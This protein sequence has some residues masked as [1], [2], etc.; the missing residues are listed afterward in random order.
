ME[1]HAEPGRKPRAIDRRLHQALARAFTIGAE[2]LRLAA[3]VEAGEFDG[4]LA[5]AVQPGKPQLAIAD[6]A[7]FGAVTLDQSPKTRT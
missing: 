5:G 2:E 3:K 6:V 1:A 7:G 4:V